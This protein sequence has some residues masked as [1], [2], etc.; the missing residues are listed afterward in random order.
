V[1]GKAPAALKAPAD[2]LLAW[3]DWENRKLDEAVG[4]FA[5][6]VKNYP[7]HA[8]AADAMFQR[9]ACLQD[10]GKFPEA[11]QQFADFVKKHPRHTLVT[12]AQYRMAVSLSRQDKFDEAIKG[13]EKLAAN[14][15]NVT[16][17]LLY[18]LAWARRGAKQNDPAIKT[19]QQLLAAYPDGRLAPS[20]RHE[21]GELLYVGEKYAEALKLLEQ[22]VKDDKAPD[23]TRMVSA[24][25]LAWCHAK[26]DQHEQAAAAFADFAGKYDDKA[27]SP[28]SFY[29]AGESYARVDK[30][31]EAATQF[32]KL[33]GKYPKHELAAVAQLKLGEVY[34]AAGDYAKS[35]SAYEAYLKNNPK[36]KYG[37]LAQF[38]IGWSF[39]NRQ[40]PEDARRW[41]AQVVEGHNGP[42][43]A[44]AQ[45]QIGE[46][47]FA[48]KQYQRAARELLKVDIVYA[49]PQWSAR[50][51][52]EA[53][54]SFEQVGEKEQA[55]RQY[56]QCLKKFKDQPVA[57][58]ARKALENL[59]RQG[60]RR[61]RRSLLSAIR[62]QVS[63]TADGL[64]MGLL[65]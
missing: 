30:H 17:N 47:Y 4:R 51:L 6:V 55:R 57:G 54:R 10:G 52:Y 26:Q 39:E 16:E 37:Y 21:L 61:V 45:F 7:D 43:A 64:G 35:Q 34:A 48:Q 44:R 25:R 36:G 50:A 46:T 11:Y 59:D 12:D 18:E 9:G 27:L 58:L 1:A 63:R 15:D 29:Q 65:G 8:L 14:K 3:V 42:T 33:I 38:G 24:Y 23:R 56:Q 60:A 13:F 28:S 31:T 62:G 22:V 53:G 20:A 19:Y 2:Y 40:K 49:Y 5:A 32:D 41:Y